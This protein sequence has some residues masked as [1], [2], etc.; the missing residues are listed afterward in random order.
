[1]LGIDVK[2]DRYKHSEVNAS[3]TPWY[4]SQVYCLC[5]LYICRY[6]HEYEFVLILSIGRGVEGIEKIKNN[7]SQNLEHKAR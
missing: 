2:K 3:V 1:M 7:S 4:T 6:K 5:M